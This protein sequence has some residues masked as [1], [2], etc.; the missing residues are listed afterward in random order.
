MSPFTQSLPLHQSAA[1]RTQQTLQRQ[2]WARGSQAVA[3]ADSALLGLFALLLNDVFFLL[4]SLFFLSFSHSRF[5]LEPLPPND[6]GKRSEAYVAA[7]MHCARGTRSDRFG[8]A[9]TSVVVFFL[10]S[11]ITV[12]SLPLLLLYIICTC[13]KQRMKTVREHCGINIGL[14]YAI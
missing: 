2:H 12:A 9:S 1:M 13:R 11:S 3:A 8:F 7:C 10:A 6:Y 5:F 14:W 4:L